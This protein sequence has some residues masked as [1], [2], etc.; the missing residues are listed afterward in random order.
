[1]SLYF[2]LNY[3]LLSLLEKEDWPALAYYL[4][5]QIY[6]KGRY[7][8]KNVR[9]LASS[10]LVITDYK[11]VLKLESKVHLARPSVIAKNALIFGA[12]RIL[13]GNHQEAVTFFKINLDKCKKSDKEWVNW[14]SGFSGLLAGLYPAAEAD[15]S[16]LAVSSKDALI[17]G[18]S[19]YFLSNY[20]E[21]KSFASEKCRKVCETGR[22]RVIKSLKTAEGWNKEV[23][24][25]GNDIHIAIIKKYIEETG[26]WI[27]AAG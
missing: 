22:E 2:I 5:Q 20:L 21:K 3:R 14:F 17:S 27:F 23:K 7:S 11:S 18:L 9:L 24:K 4:E 25:A 13:D 8:S 19:V 16:H 1:M 6:S 15:F 26:N 12:A 10:Y